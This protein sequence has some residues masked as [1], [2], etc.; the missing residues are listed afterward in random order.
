MMSV[1]LGTGG[2][3]FSLTCYLHSLFF[4]TLSSETIIED[5]YNYF[6]FKQLY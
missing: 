2:Y 3:K 4:G 5:F 1:V 6:V